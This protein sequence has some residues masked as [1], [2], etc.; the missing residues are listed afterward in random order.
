MESV[1]RKSK[2]KSDD[3]ID[4]RALLD[5]LDSGIVIHDQNGCIIAVNQAA[6]N[7]LNAEAETIVGIN[8]LEHA[9][10]TYRLDGSKWTADETP[11]ATAL[12]NGT[13]VHGVTIGVDVPDGQ[14]ATKRL[15]T[16]TNTKL[17][18]LN[19]GETGVAATFTDVTGLQDQSQQLQAAYD[20]FS[21]LIARSDSIITLSNAE[22]KIT[23]ASPSFS[24]LTGVNEKDV[25]GTFIRDY[26]HPED[27]ESEADKIEYLRQNFG[28]TADLNFRVR[29]ANK[30]WRHLEI[31]STNHLNDPAI[32]GIVGNGRDVTDRVKETAGLAYQATHD[33]L[34]GLANRALL[35]DHLDIAIARAKRSGIPIALYYMDIDGFKKVNDTYGHSAGDK[36][37]VTVTER[38][39]EAT[40]PGDTI[41]RIGGDEFVM[42]AEGILDITTALSI[43][44]RVRKAI[45]KPMLLADETINISTSIGISLSR[46]SNAQTM[47]DEADSAL[48]KAKH[49]GG[50]RFEIYDE[51]MKQDIFGKSVKIALLENMI[52]NQDLRLTFLPVV[53]LGTHKVI[54]ASANFVTYL[55][56]NTTMALSDILPFAC[57]N[58]M[59]YELYE[60]VL[61]HICLSLTKRSA[62]PGGEEILQ[63]KCVIRLPIADKLLLDNTTPMHISS[64]IHK[65]GLPKE[66]FCFEVSEQALLDTGHYALTTISEFNKIGFQILL[67]NVGVGWSNFGLLSNLPISR[68]KTDPILAEQVVDDQE[69]GTIVKA[70]SAIGNALGLLTVACGVRLRS[71]TKILS[72]I[73]YSEAEG[74]LFGHAITIDELHVTK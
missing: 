12:K 56:D 36:L 32:Q 23:Y 6:C 64:L 29:T 42:L 66:M 11:V 74:P 34:T 8:A 69:S 14:G 40:R 39:K 30:S 61:N 16:L 72:D 21:T 49:H 26:I 24:K 19:S 33:A 47:I 44:E 68:M 4:Y 43:A 67:G 2:E 58:S 18:K 50:N 41:A 65:H 13:E 71:Q 55:P 25:L 35:L 63:S 31:V 60:V 53:D 38:L 20:K 46:S 73:G 48:Y 27:L 1:I 59:G 28:A 62:A 5:D 10:T 37:I 54:A 15:W 70:I 57:D 3:L 52:Q 45:H 22:G 9:G 51:V 17:I 7:M